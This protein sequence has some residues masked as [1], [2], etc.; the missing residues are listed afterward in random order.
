MRKLTRKQIVTIV[1]SAVIVL[2]LIIAGIALG[3][4][5]NNN[6]NKKDTD[7]KVESV[8]KEEKD[9]A[10]KEDYEAD[11]SVEEDKAETT[12]IGGETADTQTDVSDS[13]TSN[14]KTN[15]NKNNTTNNTTNKVTSSTKPSQTVTQP[16]TGHVHNWTEVKTQV[17]V[18]ETGHYETIYG[19]KTVCNAC[20][21]D[22]SELT[23][24]ERDD[25]FKKELCRY[26]TYTVYRVET[27]QKWI[28]DTP[29]TTEARVTG[30]KCSCG[31]TR[32]KTQYAGMHSLYD[33]ASWDRL[34][35]CHQFF[36]QGIAGNASE[37]DGNWV[38]YGNWESVLV[39]NG[40]SDG[41]WM[42]IFI[43]DWKLD[44]YS[45]LQ[46]GVK[47][48]IIDQEEARLVKALY[49]EIPSIFKGAIERV[50]P[51]GGTEL[52][53]YVE[54]LI[55]QAKGNPDAVPSL[56]GAKGIIQENIPGLYVTIEETRG[57]FSIMFWAE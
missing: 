8:A 11:K 50:A 44:D 17:A 34:N 55:V 43:R 14:N 40:S 41:A 37:L 10:E 36:K 22:I 26:G 38:T 1:V 32:E 12:E 28:V 49:E 19:Q 3:T 24:D 9:E 25:H 27:G 7:K 48:G 53:N 23:R 16:T 47:E 13:T 51:E 31:A 33:Q 45:Y 52:Y 46:D 2:A 18:P 56:A 29:A 57:G 4:K 20:Q 5:S 6:E 54:K 15:N 35:A 21:T 30:Y 39:C 42:W